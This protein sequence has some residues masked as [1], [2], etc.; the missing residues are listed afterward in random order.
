MAYL[1]HYGIK[2]RSGRYP[3]GSGKDPYQHSEDFISRIEG[4]KKNGYSDQD[5]VK[6]F[7]LESRDQLQAYIQIAKTARKE[8]D[9]QTAISMHEHGK[10]NAEIAQAL[11]YKNESNIRALFKE[12][13]LAKGKE[14]RNLADFLSQQIEEKGIVDIGEGVELHLGVSRTKL[15]QAMEMV[16]A[17]KGYLK[18]G[19]QID[20]PLDPKS[21]KKTTVYILAK[22][23][24]TYQAGK[25][26][27]GLIHNLGKDYTSDDNGQTFRKVQYPSSVDISRVAILHGDEYSKALKGKGEDF[28]GCIMLRRGVDDLNLGGPSYAQVR[29]MVNGSHYLK[30]MAVYSDDLPEGKDILFCTN[31]KSG[32]DWKQV[33]KPIKDDPDNPFGATLTAEGQSTY[34]DSNGN[35]RLSPIN[36]LKSEGEWD[37]ASS[38]NLSSQFLSK[39]PLKLI[40]QQTDISKQSALDQLEEIR[41]ISNQTLKKKL[42][43]DYADTQDA[44]AMRLKAAALPGQKTHVILPVNSLK[45]N[46]IF[47]PNYKDG[48][49]LAL[50]R[51]PHAS[52]TEI[53]ILKVNSKNP[54]A[55]SRIGKN[56]KDAVGI[57][58]KVAARLSGADFD[59]DFVIAIPIGPKSKIKNAHPYPELIGFDPKDAYQTYPGKDKKGND[60]R[61]NKYGEPVKIISENTKQRQMGV[62]SNLITDM[63]LS[64]ADSKDIAKA[65]RHS[66][67]V[68]DAVKHELDYNKSYRENDIQRLKDTY[69][70]SGGAKTLISKRKQD[71]RVP[72]RVGYGHIDKETGEVS[73]K[74]SG[75]Y[76]EE[77]VPKKVKDPISGKTVIEKDIYG[78]PVKVGTGKM[79]AATQK[80]KLLLE[81]KDLHS[82]S[83]GTAQEAIYADYGNYLKSLANQ[84]RKETTT[85][86]AAPYSP[87]A[88]KL[89]SKE[90][91]E[92]NAALNLARKN[93]PKE[94]LAKAKA[95]SEINERLKSNP[96]ISDGDAKKLRSNVMKK[97]RDL[98]GADGRGTKI[99]ISEAQWKAIQ[100]GAITDSKLKSI[101]EFS[102]ME[103]VKK[104]ALPREEGKLRDSQISRLTS[105]KN[106]GYSNAEIAEALGISTS[107]VSKYLN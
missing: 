31:K 11:G 59:G 99:S 33:L 26:D 48:E 98:V 95:N 37:T 52:I 23:E 92:L 53:P 54:E 78:R 107:T 50:I 70:G 24:E 100:A 74:E 61:V 73:Y 42:L 77:R 90:V 5:L 55:A 60:I 36:K 83:S 8:L 39:Q 7:G 85:I 32:K 65:M 96:D 67:C 86:K 57:N 94:R 18:G 46:E 63:T 105:M 30:G 41:S 43:F 80:S 45:D 40:K 82:I 44:N 9:R 101:L 34:L 21:S 14:I 89:Y 106:S 10:T 51:Y 79:V 88:N 56:A 29:I 84:A 93:K 66:M 28:D 15:N 103:Q 4:L 35:K 102:D 2:R 16:L 6:E 91:S 72:E 71:V 64:G 62:V 47:A 68:I 38:K 22:D 49:S 27:P 58:S 76:Y 104:L 3:W 12:D 1:K 81:T 25:N 97:N 17:E 19:Y 75:R 20:N 87:E 69:Q 13:A